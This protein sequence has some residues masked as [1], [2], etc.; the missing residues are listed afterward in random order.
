MGTWGVNGETESSKNFRSC[1]TFHASGGGLRLRGIET[2][3]RLGQCEG[4]VEG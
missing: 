1:K 2:T 3:Y 4:E